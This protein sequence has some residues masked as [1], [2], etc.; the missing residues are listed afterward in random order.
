MLLLQCNEGI[1]HRL[2]LEVGI[3]FWDEVGD[4]DATECVPSFYALLELNEKLCDEDGRE[5]SLEGLRLR[6]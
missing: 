3:T 5:G 1:W 4:E 2:F 6:P